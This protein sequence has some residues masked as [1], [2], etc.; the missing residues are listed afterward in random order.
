MLKFCLRTGVLVWLSTVAL[1]AAQ[2]TPKAELFGGYSYLKGN[3]T[4]GQGFSLNGWDASLTGNLN[5]RFGLEA[6]FSDHY[7]KSAQDL[8][9]GTPLP[10][11]GPFTYAPRFTFLFGPHFSY[12]SAPRITPFAHALF[13]GVQGK[14]TNFSIDIACGP[15]RNPCSVTKSQMA[16]AMNFGGGIDLRADRHISIRLVEGDYMRANFTGNPQNIMRIS[17]GIVLAI[18]GR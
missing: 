17:A 13:G 8:A 6:N 9:N 7:G 15:P 10:A 3:P 5:R 16:F 12:T 4:S 11:S 1:A 14:A 18:G 2:D